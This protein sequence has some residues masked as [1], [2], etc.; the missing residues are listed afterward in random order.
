VSDLHSET[1]PMH[2]GQYKN[3]M[4][5]TANTLAWIASVLGRIIPE[6][7]I[8]HDRF[9]T[10]VIAYFAVGI[11]AA[12]AIVLIYHWPKFVSEN[13]TVS[14][15]TVA[16]ET[17]ITPVVPP[18]SNLEVAPPAPVPMAPPEATS[19][20]ETPAPDQTIAPETPSPETTPTP[21]PSP[22]QT[23]GP[24]APEFVTDTATL[25]VSGQTIH[26]HGIFGQTG[27]LVQR[28]ES[29]INEQGG[30][31]TCALADADTYSCTTASGHDLAAAALLNG[32][33]RAA[34]GASENYQD[35]QRQAQDA[36]RGIWGMDAP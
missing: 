33:A 1:D 24:S 2:V 25:S 22:E 11:A 18:A 31:I 12:F 35:Y 13:A 26:L 27:V 32:A 15:A 29:F 7:W 4:A 5:D 8:R 19:P 6:G 36:R 17:P 16:P 10:F 21:S 14:S 3:S 9:R 34:P 28:M 30:T 23:L 20:T